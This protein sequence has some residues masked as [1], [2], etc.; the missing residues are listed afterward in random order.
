MG[1]VA[2]DGTKDVLVELVKSQV[3]NLFRAQDLKPN[4]HKTSEEA[5]M[6]VETGATQVLEVFS[7]KYIAARAGDHGLRPRFALDL[8]GTT[9]SGPSEGRHWV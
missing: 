9:P 6:M 7:P 4:E 5:A 8:C 3:R 1:D 2:I